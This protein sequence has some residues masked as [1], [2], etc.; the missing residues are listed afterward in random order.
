MWRGTLIG[1]SIA[2][3]CQRGS[4]LPEALIFLDDPVQGY[5][6]CIDRYIKRYYIYIILICVLAYIKNTLIQTRMEGLFFLKVY[7]NNIYIYVYIFI[8]QGLDK[9]TIALIS[10]NFPGVFGYY[11]VTLHRRVVEV[12]ISM[13]CAL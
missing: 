1:Q 7:F 12:R 13:L 5:V 11:G 8:L 2:Q 10:I 4:R 9:N 6:R 3:R